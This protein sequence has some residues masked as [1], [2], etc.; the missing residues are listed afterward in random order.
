VSPPTP[1]EQDQALASLSGSEIPANLDADIARLS[2]IARARSIGMPW[3]SIGSA[4][5]MDAK[6]AKATAK[7]L[8]RDTRRQLIAQTPPADPGGPYEH[9]LGDVVSS[10]YVPYSLPIEPES[11]VSL[12]GGDPAPYRQATGVC[13]PCSRGDHTACEGG[14]GLDMTGCGCYVRREDEAHDWTAEFS[15][16]EI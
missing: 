2:L 13:E 7:R 14:N 15:G 10:P 11:V 8:A 6:T 5:G 1:A 9:E 3:A 12:P 4:L 16:G